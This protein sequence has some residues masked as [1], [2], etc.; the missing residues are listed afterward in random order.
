MKGHQMASVK[1]QGKKDFIVI[2]DGVASRLLT[3][4]QATWLVLDF[5]KRGI[6]A[7]FF[8]YGAFMSW[9]AGTKTYQPFKGQ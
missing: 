2:R 1:G 6:V 7:D 3:I 9:D 8:H 5:A 4:G